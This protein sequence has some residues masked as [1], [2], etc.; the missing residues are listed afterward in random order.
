MPLAKPWTARPGEKRPH[1]CRILND[2]DHDRFLIKP[3]SPPFATAT[4]HVRG[5]DKTATH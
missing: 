3:T 2:T 5:A 1:P 4:T